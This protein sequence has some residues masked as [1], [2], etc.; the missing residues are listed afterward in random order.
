MPNMPMSQIPNPKSQ[1]GKTFAEKVL[2][3]ASG[4]REVVAGQIVDA[5]PEVAL[6]HDNTAAIAE[7]FA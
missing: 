4:Q 7:I 2:A 6:S 3:R 5:V 1:N